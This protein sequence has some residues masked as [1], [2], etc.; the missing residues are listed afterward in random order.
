MKC[1]IWLYKAFRTIWAV[2]YHKISTIH[3]QLIFAFNGIHFG[4]G[5]LSSGV[6][7]VHISLNGLCEIGQKFCCGNWNKTSASGTNGKCKIEVRNGAVLKIGN[8]VGMTATTVICHNQITIMDN[9]MIGVGTHI[10]DTN[11]HN[12]NPI[13]RTANG[14]PQDTVRTAPITIKK[15]AFIGAYCIILKGVTIGENSVI[16]AGA[17]VTKS[18][19]DNQMWGGNPAIFIRKLNS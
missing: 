5:L 9:V 2:A 17:V 12:I 15:N 18:I 13:E 6:P 10:Y 3:T 7:I 8:N 1:L 14:D 19:P 11:F 16:A 4:K